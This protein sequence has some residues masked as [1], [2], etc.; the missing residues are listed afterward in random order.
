M[1]NF[2]GRNSNMKLMYFEIQLSREKNH[3]IPKGLLSQIISVMLTF[4]FFAI[5]LFAQSQNIVSLDSTNYWIYQF[6]TETY[7]GNG[8][9][10]N[11]YTLVYKIKD[12]ISYEGSEL[13]II[14]ITEYD[15]AKTESGSDL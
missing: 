10:S 14:G 13:K 1:Y 2:E 9:K 12:T 7:D 15:T 5:S 11:S 6:D 3:S 8:V 4:S